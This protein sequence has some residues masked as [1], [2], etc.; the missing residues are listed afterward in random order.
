MGEL[1][2]FPDQAISHPEGRWQGRLTA[3]AETVDNI[4]S[5]TNTLGACLEGLL[6]DLRQLEET[7]RV[8]DNL[9]VRLPVGEA[10]RQIECQQ[11]LVDEQLVIV[12]KLLTW[13]S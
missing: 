7:S 6:S 5:L 11:G 4:I 8:L 13:S 10:R 1:L 3:A 2:C 12:R 9:V